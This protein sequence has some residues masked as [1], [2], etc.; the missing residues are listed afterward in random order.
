MSNPISEVIRRQSQTLSP[1]ECDEEDCIGI[2]SSNQTRPLD[3][4]TN[5]MQKRIFIRTRTAPTNGTICVRVFKHR[6]NAQSAVLYHDVA[7]NNQNDSSFSITTLNIMI[8]NNDVVTRPC[9]I[10]NVNMIIYIS[11]YLYLMQ[12]LFSP[13]NLIPNYIYDTSI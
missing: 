9:R 4:L 8:P 10:Q 1:T 2:L 3:L 5:H 12:Y 7:V 13:T 6:Q 11:F